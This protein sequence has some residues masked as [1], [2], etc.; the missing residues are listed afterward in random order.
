MSLAAD[1]RVLWSLLRGAAREGSHAQRL[2][3]FY[4]PQAES[5]DA[6]R[7]RLLHG[8]RELIQRLPA[9]RGGRVIELGGG[10]G[11]NL[12]FFGPRIHRLASVELVDLCPALLAVAAQRLA[13]LTAGGRCNGRVIEADATDYRPADAPDCVYFSYALTMIPDWRRAIDN[14]LSMLAPGGTLGVVDF[15]LPAGAGWSNRFWKAWF[16]HDAVRLSG[17]HLP[18][19]EARL[20]AVHCEALRGRVPFLPG[21]R[22]PYYL[23]IGRK[24]ATPGG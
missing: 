9:R 14:A 12:D 8:R 13:R 21:L 11:R 24:P 1:A 22:V 4:A 23:F 3:A 10:T 5:Y 17:E 6:F 18:Y 15:H 7:E 19:L 20:Q 16:A 2:Q